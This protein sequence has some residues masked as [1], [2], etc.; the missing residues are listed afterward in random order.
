MV[1][2]IL[3]P[4]TIGEAARLVVRPGTAVLGGGTWLNSGIAASDAAGA[5]PVT[6]RSG[7]T[8]LALISLESL[9]LDFVE[10]R[11]AALRI[12]AMA[13]FQQILDAPGVPEALRNAVA[14]TSSRTLR[15]MVTVG[16]ELGH[17]PAD[18]VLIPV[19]AALDARVRIAGR[20]PLGI[21]E[22][23]SARALGPVG[24]IVEVSAS[25]ADGPCAVAS[26]FRTSHGRRSLVIAVSAARLHPE[27]SRVRIVAS[28]CRG[29][30]LRLAD[31]EEA[32]EGSPLPAKDRIEKLVRAA[33]WP[34]SDIHASTE[35]K[36]YLAGVYAADLLHALA[37]RQASS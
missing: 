31:A 32:L 19:F 15:T 23:R 4:K 30:V 35:Y 9:G 27:V 18:S 36:R 1:S 17:C 11:N 14:A 20:S 28:D 29:Q 34:T 5:A 37:G 3:R 6:A 25:D 8:P 22:Y 21:E 12:G 24:L 33:F 7:S 16:G 13:T 2:E 26:L 10:W